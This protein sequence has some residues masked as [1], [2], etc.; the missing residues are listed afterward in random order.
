MVSTVGIARTEILLGKVEGGE[1]GLLAALAIVEVVV[2]EA[3]HGGGVGDG[4]F[5]SVAALRRGG[6]A[7]EEVMRR[8]KVDLP[9]PGRGQA[10]DDGAVRL[11]RGDDVATGS[12]GLGGSRELRLGAEGLA[13]RE[14]EHAADMVMVVAIVA[15]VILSNGLLDDATKSG[16]IAVYPVGPVSPGL[17]VFSIRIGERKDA[18]TMDLTTARTTLFSRLLSSNSTNAHRTLVERCIFS[19]ENF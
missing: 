16:R 4:V 3:Q 9:Q 2:I 17:A 5:E 12:A 18:R 8:M 14:G 19:L 1:A 13:G 10:D 7:A 11:R 6:L 15:V